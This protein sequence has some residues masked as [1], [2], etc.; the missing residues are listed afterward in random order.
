MWEAPRKRSN[1]QFDADILSAAAFA[2]TAKHSKIKDIF[3]IP[4]IQ[5]GIA[6]GN[7]LRF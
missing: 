5:A 7:T 1:S 2:L 4:A 3:A 6:F